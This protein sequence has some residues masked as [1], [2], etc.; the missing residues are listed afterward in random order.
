MDYILKHYSR[1][2]PVQNEPWGNMT[3]MIL[4][5][6]ATSLDH[7]HGYPIEIAWSLPDGQVRSF[8][9]N[10]AA[11]ASVLDWCE[12]S[13][14]QHG[15][16]LEQSLSEGIDPQVV[17]EQF[18]EDLGSNIPYSDAP[19]HDYLWLSKLFKMAGRS[20]HFGQLM[21]VHDLYIKELRQNGFSVHD[22]NEIAE[23]IIEVDIE[24][25]RLHR[26]ASDVSAIMYGLSVAQTLKPE[27]K[28]HA[29]EYQ[30]RGFELDMASGMG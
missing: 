25:H 23:R 5:I 18:L 2:K 1:Q 19:T 28:I 30:E 3:A 4:D 17:I 21:P 13:H 14:E 16:T 11:V 7:F 8:L 10:L 22:A 20:L 9:I 29:K 6:E 15:I 26:A 12:F 27:V 24:I